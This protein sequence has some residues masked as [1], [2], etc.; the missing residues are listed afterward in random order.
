LLASVEA[1]PCLTGVNE[2]SSYT[3][4]LIAREL[5]LQRTGVHYRG[6]RWEAHLLKAI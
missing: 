4:R 2:H 6:S 3:G 5:H 1:G